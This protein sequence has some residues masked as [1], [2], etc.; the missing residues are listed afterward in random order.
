MTKEILFRGLR[1]DG[2]GWVEGDKC[3]FA[4]RHYIIPENQQFRDIEDPDLE[5]SFVEVIPETVGQY[6]GLR[7]KNGKRVFEGDKYIDIY[8][9]IWIIGGLEF[10]EGALSWVQTHAKSGRKYNINDNLQ[11]FEIIGNVHEKEE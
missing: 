3:T 9:N 5:S 8:G 11:K 7:D 4:G 2:N 1:V 10:F 6:T